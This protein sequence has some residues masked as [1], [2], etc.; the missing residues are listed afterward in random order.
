MLCW[1]GYDLFGVYGMLLPLFASFVLLNQFSFGIR[2]C[3][4]R[5][6]TAFSNSFAIIQKFIKLGKLPQKYFFSLLTAFT[7]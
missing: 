5:V 7:W 1:T 4:G 2:L 3:R 6:A